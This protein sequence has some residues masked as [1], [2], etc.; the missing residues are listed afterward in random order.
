MFEK[1]IFYT[2][3]RGIVMNVYFYLTVP[4]KAF[5]DV[6]L[7]KIRNV[8]II[9]RCC[10]QH[11]K[12]FS[13]VANNAEKWSM[14]LLT[15]PIIFCV[16]AYSAEKYSNFSSHVFFSVL[17]PTQRNNYWNCWQRRTMFEFEYPN[18]FKQ[19]ANLN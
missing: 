1:W 18:E 19:Y 3:I 17:L 12:I 14:L 7:S 5:S 8:V 11:R 4:L 2:F 9:L 13:F 16:I 6:L 15:T 10:R